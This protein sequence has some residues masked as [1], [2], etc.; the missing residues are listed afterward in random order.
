M[1]SLNLVHFLAKAEGMTLNVGL[2]L[3]GGSNS[4]PIRISYELAKTFF[5]AG[6]IGKLGIRFKNSSRPVG[7]FCPWPTSFGSIK[8][9]AIQK[10]DDELLQKCPEVEC[11][12]KEFPLFKR[13]TQAC[14]AVGGIDVPIGNR[15]Y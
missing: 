1:A 9:L 11:G 7:I 2:L 13:A 5:Y 10:G 8:K 4:G 14:T 15:V 6:S 3:K 12:L